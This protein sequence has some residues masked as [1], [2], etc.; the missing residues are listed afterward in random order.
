MRPPPTPVPHQTPSTRLE[1][2][3]GAEL[4]LGVDR[5]R[6]RRCRSR[7]A[8]RAPCER[9]SPSGNEP[10][11]AGQVA[12][13][14]DHAGLLVGVAGRA[15]ADAGQ[16]AGADA[17]PARPP[18]ASLRPSPRRRPRGRPW[19]GSAAA[20]RRGPCCAASDHDRL[21]LGPAEVD[22]AARCLVAVGAHAGDDIR[23]TPGRFEKLPPWRRW[24]NGAPGGSSGAGTSATAAGA[25]AGGSTGTPP[26]AASS[27]ATRSRGRCSRR[28]TRAAWRSARGPCSSPAAG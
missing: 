25:G 20:P 7:P 3:A 5:D 14:G 10:V 9:C 23:A 17:R 19:S 4:E 2:L 11:P 6:R 8:P 27:S 26:R 1:R 21:D 13:V 16:V 22:A 18:R 28:S 12:G 15:D 24:S